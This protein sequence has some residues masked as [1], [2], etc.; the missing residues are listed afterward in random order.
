MVGFLVFL[1]NPIFTLLFLWASYRATSISQKLFPKSNMTN[2]IGNAFRHSLWCSLIL[3]YCCKVSSPE[4]SLV[5]CKK[6]TNLHEEFFPNESLETKM[7][8]HNNQVG[9]DYFMSLLSEIHR[10]FFETSFLV[11]GLLKKTETAQKINAAS[12][13]FPTELVYLE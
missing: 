11:N 5:F 4:K 9:M 1:Q 6:I 10:Q 7:D 2:G 8:L 12:D 13:N 3:M